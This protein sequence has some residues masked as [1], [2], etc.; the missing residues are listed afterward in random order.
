MPQDPK[1]VVRR[2]FDTLSTGEFE[3]IAECFTEDSTWTVNDVAN[4][5][6]SQRG[7]AIIDDFLQPV[8]E[9][10]FE[11]GDPKVEVLRMISEGSTV[12]AETI[13][14]GA[15]RNGNLYENY[16]AWFIEV[17][18]ETG[19]VLALK[20]YMDSDYA[21][22]I[23]APTGEGAPDAQYADQLRSLGHEV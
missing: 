14:R 21:H 22:S 12:A 20:E 23:S 15:L 16:Y 11:A 10:L 1:D 4:G 19:K 5:F 7:R 8:R 2:F 9:G 3:K 17:D 18:T 13:A 6:P